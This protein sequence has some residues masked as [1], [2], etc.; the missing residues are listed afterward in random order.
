MEHNNIAQRLTDLRAAKGATQE[1]VAQELKVSN[2]TVS[3]WETGASL[4]DLD[5][6]VALARYYGVSTDALLGI[7]EPQ[8]RSVE[9]LVRAEFR[10]LDRK[11]VIRKAFALVDAVIP[12]CM[13]VVSQGGTEEHNG[14]EALP[15]QADR[16]MSRDCVCAQD[17]FDFVASSEDVNVAVML[18]RNRADFAWLKQPEKQKKI[19]GFFGFLS[20]VDALSV[21]YFLHS[22]ACPDSFTADYV[23]KQTGV[24]EAKAAEILDAS[25][26]V[27]ECHRFTAHL[28]DGE[29]TV[30]E[31]E[32]D[33]MVLSVITLAYERMCGK[34]S[35]NYYYGNA[36]GK[37]IGGK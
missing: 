10:G 35:Y 14:P 1:A 17:F 33:G 6:L 34:R 5:M 22:A 31:C 37:M 19:A 18:L 24:P 21:C 3:K 36:S 9:E 27:G 4:P 12:A 2:K 23:A 7:A 29:T 25:C 20:D 16:Q 8:E 13:E 30:Y 32:N 28:T 11:E 15:P 26:E